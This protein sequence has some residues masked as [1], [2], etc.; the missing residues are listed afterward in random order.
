MD[1]LQTQQQNV[2][3]TRNDFQTG[4]NPL[5]GNSGSLQDT[6]KI[7]GQNLST[8]PSGGG[9]R[10]LPNCTTN[11]VESQAQSASSEGTPWSA[12]QW[13]FWGLL[14]VIVFIV[15]YKLISREKAV[16]PVAANSETNQQLAEK[17]M[18]E[19]TV[20]L[21]KTSKRSAKKAKRK[22]RR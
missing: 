9:L 5:S 17:K 20:A 7:G 15:I 14:F 10:V 3:G 2:F 22:N 13:T 16:S 19:E 11:C 18:A 1:N 12:A 4:Q 8:L 21:K 6:T